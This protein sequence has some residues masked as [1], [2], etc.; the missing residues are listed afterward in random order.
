M[1]TRTLLIL[2]IMTVCLAFTA[3]TTTKEDETAQLKEQISQLE[4]QIQDLQEN[5]TTDPSGDI[6]VPSENSPTGAT[7]TQTPAV[8][9]THHD[10]HDQQQNTTDIPDITALSARI[11]DLAQRVRDTTPTGSA[12]EQWEQFNSLDQEIESAEQDL[13]RSEDA[14]EIQYQSG[15]LDQTSYRE[16]EQTIEELED[17]LDQCEDQLEYTF[18]L[19]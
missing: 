6:S 16:T 19:S 11:Q 14:L 2:A 5:P 15:T 4:Q 13:D 17:L 12:Q 8:G 10:G 7:V 9:N 1:K 18:K 3:C